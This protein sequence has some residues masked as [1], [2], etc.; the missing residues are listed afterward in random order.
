MVL[1][2]KHPQTGDG[3]WWWIELWDNESTSGPSV[4]CSQVTQET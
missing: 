2:V 3:W 4:L 1:P